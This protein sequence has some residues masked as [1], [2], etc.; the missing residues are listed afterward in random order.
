MHDF[1]KGYVQCFSNLAD[2]EL[3]PNT[4]NS[5]TWYLTVSLLKHA[6]NVELA[7]PSTLIVLSKWHLQSQEANLPTP[8]RVAQ[9]SHSPHDGW[10]QTIQRRGT[11]SRG[12]VVG[13]SQSYHET[14]LLSKK[15]ELMSY[16]VSHAELGS[17][18]G[19]QEYCPLT[20][21]SSGH[22]PSHSFYSKSNFP[23]PR[24]DDQ[25]AVPMPSSY[26][27][28]KLDNIKPAG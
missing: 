1:L 23:I 19:S 15:A 10:S 24:W 11:G 28:W 8:P 13:G 6:L 2:F 9:H 12:H 16:D 18:S 4:P 7:A 3:L 20:L 27:K 5:S 25:H 22:V 17:A 14:Y 21:A 26:N